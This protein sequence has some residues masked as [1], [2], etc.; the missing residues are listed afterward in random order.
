MTLHLSMRRKAGMS[1]ATEAFTTQKMAA[2][3]GKNKLK[4]KEH[5]SAVLLL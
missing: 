2:T 5:F 3:P 1:M 4:R